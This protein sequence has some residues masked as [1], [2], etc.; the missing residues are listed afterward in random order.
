MCALFSFKFLLGIVLV[1]IDRQVNAVTF[2]FGWVANR[3]LTACIVAGVIV[4]SVVVTCCSGFRILLTVHTLDRCI[5]VSVICA[6]HMI[7]RCCYGVTAG[8]FIIGRAVIVRSCRVRYLGAFVDLTTGT[9]H[10]V[11]CIVVIRYVVGVVV[12]ELRLND[13]VITRPSRS[14]LP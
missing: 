4:V 13:A 8:A 11:M 14:K 6:C 12:R 3:Y 7:L 9:S 10:I 5:A 1:C 2:I